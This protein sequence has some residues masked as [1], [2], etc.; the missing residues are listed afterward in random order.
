MEESGYFVILVRPMVESRYR[1]RSL[2]LVVKF[3]IDENRNI[4][5]GSFELI[6][7]RFL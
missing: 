4:D 6:S 5:T 2:E 3:D 7:Q 1:G